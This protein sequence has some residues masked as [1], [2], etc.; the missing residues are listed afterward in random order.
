MTSTNDTEGP[1][2]SAAQ[3]E[4]SVQN[5][6]NHTN[7][8]SMFTMSDGKHTILQVTKCAGITFHVKCCSQKARQSLF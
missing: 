8:I 7:N 5:L 2:R 3:I 4:N 6:K 1:I